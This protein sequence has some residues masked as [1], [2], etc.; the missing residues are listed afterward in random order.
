MEVNNRT[1]ELHEK[2]SRLEEQNE[3]IDEKN[4][5]ITASILYAKRI[6]Q[7]LMATEKQI[8]KTLGRLKK[9]SKEKD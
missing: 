3:I 6:Q 7:S 8:E 1:K 5:N 9:K 4:K 2:N